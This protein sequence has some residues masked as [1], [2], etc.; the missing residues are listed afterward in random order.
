MTCSKCKYWFESFEG[1]LPGWCWLNDR[2]C[3]GHERCCL[4]VLKRIFTVHIKLWFVRRYNKITNLIRTI[5]RN[6]ERKKILNRPHRDS[7]KAMWDG[8]KDE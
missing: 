1:I 4:N 6:R 3:F 8:V 7:M 2:D 5:K